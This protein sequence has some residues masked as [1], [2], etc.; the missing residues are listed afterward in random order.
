M[1]PEESRRRAMLA[2]QILNND[3]W[4][5]IGPAIEADIVSSWASTEDRDAR[6]Y[7]W[8]RLQAYREILTAL[9]REIDTAVMVNMKEA[10]N[11]GSKR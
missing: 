5:E 6:D 11:A 3:L 4:Q 9:K 1:T 8:H 7:L 10:E 2:Q